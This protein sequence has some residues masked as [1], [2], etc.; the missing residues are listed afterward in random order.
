MTTR[1]RRT[2]PA[3]IIARAVSMPLTKLLHAF[4]TSKAWAREPSSA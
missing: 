3:R 1:A 4:V 2:R